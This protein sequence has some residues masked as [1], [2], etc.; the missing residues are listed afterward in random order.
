ME[1]NTPSLRAQRKQAK[2]KKKKEQAALKKLP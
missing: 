2:K 1:F